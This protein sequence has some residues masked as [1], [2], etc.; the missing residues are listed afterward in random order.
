MALKG[1]ARKRA[2]REI[3]TALR[4]YNRAV[5]NI[6]KTLGKEY[7]PPK[8]SAEQIL[9]SAKNLKDVRGEI[10]ELKKVRSR[11]AKKIVEGEGGAKTT[12]YTLEQINRLNELRNQERERRKRKVGDVSET[13]GYAQSQERVRQEPKNVKFEERSDKSFKSFV[14]QLEKEMLE[15]EAELSKGYKANYLNALEINIGIEARQEIEEML[16]GINGD[17]LY[18]ASLTLDYGDL[19]TVGYAYIPEDIEEIKNSLVSGIIRLRRYLG[20]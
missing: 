6:E 4:E 17:E 2:E 10:K 3:R 9:A 20:K 18:I 11:S 1:K 5:K 19:F 7:A 14:S 8:R 12:E 16:Q 15:N 13:P